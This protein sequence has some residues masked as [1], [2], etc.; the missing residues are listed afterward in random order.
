MEKNKPEHAMI[1]CNTCDLMFKTTGLLRRHTRLKHS[2]VLTNN[3][4]AGDDFGDDA[5]VITAVEIDNQ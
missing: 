4:K 5:T 1:K 3:K 2:S